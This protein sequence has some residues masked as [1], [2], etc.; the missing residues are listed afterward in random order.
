MVFRY[1]PPAGYSLPSQKYARFGY[2]GD[3]WLPGMLGKMRCIM[4]AANSAP[5]SPSAPAI[6]L[7]G[8][9]NAGSPDS[10]PGTSDS[11]VSLTWSNQIPGDPITGPGPMSLQNGGHSFEWQCGTNLAIAYNS[12]IITAKWW[13]DGAVIDL[14]KASSNF[15]WPNLAL[16]LENFARQ[17]V[18]ANVSQANILFCQGESNAVAA[19]AGLLPTYQADVQ[20]VF[21]SVKGLLEGYGLNV[22]FTIIMTNVGCP[23]DSPS[24]LTAVRGYQTAIGAARTDTTVIDPP[25]S[26]G[27]LHYINGASNIIGTIIASSITSIYTA[28]QPAFLAAST[29]ESI[30]G[31]AVLFDYDSRSIVGL[32]NSDP[33]SVWPD[34]SSGVHTINI[35]GAARPQYLINA[36]GSIPEV[37][38]DGVANVANTGVSLVAPGTTPFCSIWVG[39]QKTWT[40]N[41][42]IW[43]NAVGFTALTQSDNS[44]EVT[45]SN[46]SSV[47]SNQPLVLNTFG[48]VENLFSHQAS[49]YQ[50]VIGSRFVTG[51][52]GNVAPGVMTMATSNGGGFGNVTYLKW[53]MLNRAPTKLERDALRGYGS[54]NY[55]LVIW[56]AL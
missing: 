20:D 34:L 52:L 38:F 33:V 28:H 26:S 35:A 11:R 48:K 7:F 36:L 43:G 49:D 31:A 47:I 17:C 16:A 19:T 4:P 46:G 8:Q 2:D 51:D 56:G 10:I 27:A 40:A 6:F 50:Q 5:S 45:P 21:D 30:M 18:A 14:F 13:Y 55:G 24:G 44:P 9:S 12:N 1:L 37:L 25:T 53:V 39:R 54:K 3:L 15:G 23:T 32:N 29:F 42:R 22:R 41:D